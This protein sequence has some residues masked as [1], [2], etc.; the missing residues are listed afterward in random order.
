MNFDAALRARLHQ[1]LADYGA[2]VRGLIDSHGIARYG[3]DPADIEQEVRIRLW[4]ALERDRNA[5]FHASYIHRT[6]LSA[7]I[8]AVRAANA[9]PAEPLPEAESAAAEALVATGPGP[10]RLAGGTQEFS[11]VAACM[12][13]LPARRREAVALH[14]QGFSLREIGGAVGVSEEAAR[15]LL[16]RGMQTLR[17]R[18]A[19]QGFGD[20]DE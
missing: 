16:D 12:A 3:I 2:R 10:E 1:L 6:V 19:A 8:D 5:A 11:R 9:R 17:E 14:L 18:L 7:V 13:G 20:F 4:R 15:K